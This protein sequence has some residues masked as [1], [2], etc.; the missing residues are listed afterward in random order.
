MSQ[1]SKVINV[2]C[3]CK[4]FTGHTTMGTCHFLFTFHC[5]Q[6]PCLFGFIVW[7]ASQYRRSS[8][9]QLIIRFLIHSVI[10]MILCQMSPDALSRIS[11]GN[12]K[13]H[14][15]VQFGNLKWQMHFSLFTFN[16][17]K[18]N[19]VGNEMSLYHM[20][21]VRCVWHGDMCQCCHADVGCNNIFQCHFLEDF[22]LSTVFNHF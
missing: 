15:K 14:L 8:D 22:K 3:C 1:V 12:H 20:S 16:L 2:L 17:L 19:F 11:E 21:S 7:V 18:L 13:L 5:T 6:T 4:I 10:I 9:S